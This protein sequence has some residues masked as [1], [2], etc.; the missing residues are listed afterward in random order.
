MTVGLGTTGLGTTGLGTIGLGTL[1]GA[2]T[3]SCRASR[4]IVGTLKASGVVFKSEALRARRVLLSVTESGGKALT[5]VSKD[6]TKDR[7][8]GVRGPY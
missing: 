2:G 8:A 3:L 6:A 1:V 5:R 7:T 4:V